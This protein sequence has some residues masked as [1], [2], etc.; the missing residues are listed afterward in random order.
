M[1]REPGRK[2]KSNHYFDDWI[3][4]NRTWYFYFKRFTYVYIRIRK[5]KRID[6]KQ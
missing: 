3:I 6:N 2:E 4:R 1:P 5:D